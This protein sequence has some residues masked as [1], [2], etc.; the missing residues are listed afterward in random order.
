MRR[1][2]SALIVHLRY[3]II[4][5]PEVLRNHAGRACD[6]QIDHVERVIWLA[7]GLTDDDREEVLEA[8][9]PRACAEVLRRVPAVQ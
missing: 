9:I 2:R 7:P 8:A 3:R 6:Y 4:D 5:S 1:R